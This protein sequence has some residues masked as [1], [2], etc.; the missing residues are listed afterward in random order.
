MTIHAAKGL[1]FPVV[2]VA[3]LGR[4]GATRQPDL[5]VEGDRVGLRLVS[6]E[7]TREKALA[8]EAIADA[9]RAAEEAEDRRVMHVAVTRAEERLILSGAVEM[10]KGWPSPGPAAAP[11]SWMGPA[12][13]AGPR[14]PV[15][16]RRPRP[17]ASG[18]RTAIPAACA[19]R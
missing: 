13:A 1:E 14:R 2:V 8:W 12:L 7:N 15:D 9:R 19:R 17:C 18:R 10:E 3:D 16:R 5:L 6:V 4:R 11:L